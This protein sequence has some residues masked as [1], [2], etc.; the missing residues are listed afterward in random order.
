MSQF[1]AFFQNRILGCL[2]VSRCQSWPK[3][4]STTETLFT[5]T[6]T[7]IS[8]ENNYCIVGFPRK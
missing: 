7:K 8:C 3:F 5:P 4:D 1:K 2:V 6:S